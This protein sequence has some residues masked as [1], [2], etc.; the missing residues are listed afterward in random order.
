MSLTLRK[1]LMT[2]I[3]FVTSDDLPNEGDR[4]YLYEYIAPLDVAMCACLQVWKEFSSTLVTIPV[5]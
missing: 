3:T 5:Y 4:S 1:I 2:M